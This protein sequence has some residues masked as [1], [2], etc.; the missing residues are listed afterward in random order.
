MTDNDADE[1]DHSDENT[2]EDN[3]DDSSEEDEDDDTDGD[4]TQEDDSDSDASDDSTENQ[5]GADQNTDTDA[6][7]ENKNTQQSTDEKTDAEYVDIGKRIMSQFKANGRMIK[8]QSVDDAIQLMQMGANY[9]KKMAGLKPSLKTLK[10]LEQHELLDPE[11][12]NYLIDL[13][14]KKPEAIKKLLKDSD[15]DPMEIDLDEESSYTPQHREISDTEMALDEVLERLQ[16]SPSYQRT[17]TVIG[18]EWDAQSRTEIAEN[19]HLIEVINGHIENGIYDQVANAVAYERSLGKLI[20]IGDFAAY[21][22]MGQYMDDNNLFVLPSTQPTSGGQ[23]TQNQSQ[24][25]NPAPNNSQSSDSQGDVQR[26]NRKKAASPTRR[27]KVTPKDN[28][29][30][31]PLE[32]SDEEFMKIN[33]LSL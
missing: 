28:S 20:G 10:L 24:V 32:M 22:Q 16:D 7:V 5:D 8:V 25:N 4:D 13:S 31:N 30:Y 19:P 18:E 15:I 33:N 2:S 11:K 1:D 29:N 14:Q 17:L 23:Q 9:H 6:S 3:D 12:I 27:S 21:Q 26:K